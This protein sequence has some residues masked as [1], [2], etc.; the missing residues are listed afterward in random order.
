[1]NFRLRRGGGGL[2]HLKVGA[3]IAYL[4]IEGALG[5]GGGHF[6]SKY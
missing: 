4:L 3:M 5:I 2:Q 1:M 6:K